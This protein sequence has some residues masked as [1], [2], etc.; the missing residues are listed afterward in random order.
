MGLGIHPIYV[1][2]GLTLVG[3]IGCIVFACR[4]TGWIKRA[5]LLLVAVILLAPTGLLASM[6]KPELVDARFRTYKRLYGDIQIGMTRAEVM[7]TVQ[8]HYPSG[9]KRMEPKVLEDSTNRLDFFMNPEGS[10]EPNCEGIFL[11]M[12]EDRVVKKSYSE[13]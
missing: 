13:D 5:M 7:T 2:A 4:A 12:Q 8:R 3:A 9:G 1:I 11:Q 10:R 6:L